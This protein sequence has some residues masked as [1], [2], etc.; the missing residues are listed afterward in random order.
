MTSS[1]EQPVPVMTILP[2]QAIAEK[3]AEQEN[4]RKTMKASVL[5][6]AAW[7]VMDS[8]ENY[9]A[10]PFAIALKAT[11]SQIGLLSGLSVLVGAVIQPLGASLVERIG[12]ER[13]RIVVL[14]VLIQALLW[15]PIALIPFLLSLGNT[16]AIAFI[17]LFSLVSIA[18]NIGGPAWASTMADVISPSL[19]GEFFARRSQLLRVI[20]FMALLAF[21]WFLGFFAGNQLVFY[22]FAAVFM[23]ACSFRLISCYYLNKMEYPK[24]ES[25]PTKQSFLSFLK[26]LRENDF[27]K[28]VLF[29]AVMNF[30]V[31]IASPFFP[32]YQLK[33]LKFSYQL[34]AAI[35]GINVVAAVL[36][37]TYWGRLSDKFGNKKVLY[38]SGLLIP[39]IPLVYLSTSNIYLL[40]LAEV[41][42]GFAWA[43]FN[44]ATFNYILEFSPNYN[45]ARY[46][47]YYNVISGVATFLGALSGS[48][49]VDS[50]IVYF[51]LVGI[52][53]IFAISGIGRMLSTL[54]FLKPVGDS[55]L[56]QG[57][58]NRRFFM[59]AIILYPMSGARS[60][61]ITGL[62]LMQK[63]E[64]NAVE[65][66][67][68]GFEVMGSKTKAGT[69][70]I[71]ARFYLD[72]EVS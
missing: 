2:H 16:A 71:K 37:Y 56:V 47:A 35:I 17:I 61:M 72:D 25:H 5:D 41:I 54:I 30:T 11:N 66:V 39:I 51:G 6:G 58:D 7:S 22:G 20:G 29:L 67:M 31:N 28:L 40:A 46:I 3:A 53:L 9:Y 13:K 43:G 8:A 15:L 60:S 44:L 26:E 70:K 33:Y 32:V 45:R 57:L 62:T 59:N 14:P 34:Y 36:T 38:A 55:K 63:A 12:G 23:I 18:G 42:S 21:G 49:L 65:R 69:K 19:R 48:L 68:K 1:Q 64:K 10:A 27:G 4:I 52:P 24:Y 50:G